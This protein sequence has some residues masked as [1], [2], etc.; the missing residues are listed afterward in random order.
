MTSGFLINFYFLTA[1]ACL[2]TSNW[3]ILESGRT[4]TQLNCISCHL[5]PEEC[6]CLQGLAVRCSPATVVEG[7]TGSDLERCSSI[8]LR[9]DLLLGRPFLTVFLEPGPKATVDDLR[10]AVGALVRWRNA[11][12][13]RMKKPF[14][15]DAALE[16]ILSMHDEMVKKRGPQSRGI[17]VALA[18]QVNSRLAGLLR[19]NAHDLIL[20]REAEELLGEGEVVTTL[21]E[22]VR[23]ILKARYEAGDPG[24]A[25][26]NSGLGQTIAE[27]YLRAMG[28]SPEA[29]AEICKRATEDILLGREPFGPEYPAD[30]RRVREAVRKALRKRPES[31][32]SRG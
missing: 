15:E 3:R 6:E 4:I 5:S 25:R 7:A 17:H 2:W 9:E 30:R 14:T 12:N 18:E 1:V 28:Y 20:R 21:D 16:A 19:E 11:V 22:A 10:L 32:E 13:S 24:S 8:W 31:E 26:Y 29:A 27:S 23:E